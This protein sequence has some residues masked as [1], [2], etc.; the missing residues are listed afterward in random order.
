MD[1]ADRVRET[2]AQAIVHREAL[3]NSFYTLLFQRAPQTQ[4][5]FKGDM[6]EQGVKLIDTLNFI[7]DH[8]DDTDQLL[9]A[10]RDLAIRHVSYGVDPAHYDMVGA[11]LIEAMG[12]IL[13]PDF[14]EA[15][16][17]AWAETYTGLV[18]YMLEEAYP[19]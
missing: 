19:A 15:A 7:I 10:A 4:V 5:L 16:G 6:Q 13:G 18:G 12:T 3:A 9:P 1:N 8:L 14:D 2:W 11:C 17:A